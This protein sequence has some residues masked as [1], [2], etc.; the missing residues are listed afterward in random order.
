M[1]IVGASSQEYIIMQKN[2]EFGIGIQ[3]HKNRTCHYKLF[4]IMECV[5]LSKEKDL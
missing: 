1:N 3:I 4:Y 5:K 2:F